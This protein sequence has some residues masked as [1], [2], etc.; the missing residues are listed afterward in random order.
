MVIVLAVG[1]TV[2]VLLLI[3]VCIAAVLL[4]APIC[5]ELDLDLEEKRADVRASWLLRLVRFRFRMEERMEAVLSVLFF[6]RDFLDPEEKKKRAQKKAKRAA[7]KREKR[8]RQEKKRKKKDQKQR[9]EVPASEVS[10]METPSVASE[11]I[12]SEDIASE[13]MDP[14]GMEDSPH[15]DGGSGRGS[16]IRESLGKLADAAGAALGYAGMF[17]RIL[18]LVRKSEVLS[19]VGPTLGKFLRRIRPRKIAGRIVFGLDDPAATGK[20]TGGIAMVPLFYE[21]ELVI[22]PDFETD[23]TYIRGTV[24]VR[25]HILLLHALILVVGLAREKRIRAF[26]GAVRKGK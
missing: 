5:Y 19:V 18:G 10:G 20:L 11:D 8:I 16:G 23:E 7:R 26:I 1:K 21:T 14:G 9:T 17:R 6:R 4:L 2:L 13:G 12:T 22:S 25:G 3:L 24:T 15:P